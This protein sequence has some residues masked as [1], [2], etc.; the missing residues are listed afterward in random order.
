MRGSAG[1]WFG[2]WKKLGQ[3]DGPRNT[4]ADVNAKGN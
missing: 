3:Q 2:D 4:E 1:K